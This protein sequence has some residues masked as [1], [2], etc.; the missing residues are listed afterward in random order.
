MVM[1]EPVYPW[2]SH[3]WGNHP[4]HPSPSASQNLFEARVLRSARRSL[5]K[6]CSTTAIW[7]KLRLR[8]CFLKEMDYSGGRSHR[9]VSQQ[10]AMPLLNGLEQP[11][12]ETLFDCSP[13]PE[14][15]SDR[16]K[17][18]VCGDKPHLLEWRPIWHPWLAVECGIHLL[19]GLPKACLRSLPCTPTFAFAA[20]MKQCSSWTNTLVYHCSRNSY[21]INS[22]NNLSALKEP[23]PFL[24]SST[25]PPLYPACRVCALGSGKACVSKL[26]L[27]N[28]FSWSITVTDFLPGNSLFLLLPSAGSRRLVN[29]QTNLPRDSLCTCQVAKCRDHSA[30][31]LLVSIACGGS[32]ILSSTCCAKFHVNISRSCFSHGRCTPRYSWRI[33]SLSTIHLCLKISQTFHRIS[34]LC[35]QRNATYLL[36]ISE[37]FS[38][39]FRNCFQKTPLL[40]AP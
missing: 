38:Q 40:T 5:T 6:W 34:A 8:T 14:L 1:G 29:F 11:R 13:R 39:D 21:Q 30:K 9:C 3:Q 2:T 28:I 35:S 12:V 37:H 20:S 32:G 7:L 36:Q 15:A 17:K 4:P 22:K 33:S 26:I 27:P 31:L 19:L 18:I 24:S 23:Q 10:D 16:R 25:S